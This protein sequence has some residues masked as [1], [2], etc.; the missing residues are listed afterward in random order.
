MTDNATRTD[1]ARAVRCNRP[2]PLQPSSAPASAVGSPPGCGGTAGRPNAQ[3]SMPDGWDRLVEAGNIHNLELAAG[4]TTGDYATTCRSWTATSTSGSRR[5]A[6]CSADRARTRQTAE[7]LQA[8]PRHERRRCSREA[9]QDDGYLDSYVQVDPPASGSAAS[10]LG[11]R[12]VLRRTSDPGRGRPAPEHRRR[13][14]C[15]TSPAGSPTWSTPTSA[16]ATARSTA[17]AATRRSRPRWSS[18]SGR[19][20]SERYLDTA[21]LLHRPARPRPAR[22]RTDFGGTTG[23][24]TCPIREAPS[25]EGHSVRQLYLLAGVADVVRRDRRR[26]LLE[27]AER[28]WEEMVATKTYLTGGVGAH[29]SDEAFGDPYELPNERSYCETCAAIASVMLSWRMLLITGEARYADLI[30]RTLYNG[31]LAGRLARTATSTS[32]PTRCRSATATLRRRRRRRTERK[33]WFRCACCPPNVMRTLASLEH[34]VVAADDTSVVLHQY[35]PGTLR[36]RSAPAGAARRAR[37]TYPW[38]GSV[39]IA[40]T[41]PGRGAWALGV[42]V[43]AWSPRRARRSTGRPSSDQPRGRLAADHPDWQPATS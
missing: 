42:R 13:P 2:T 27:A 17:S 3:V 43:P 38:D 10:P 28:L 5:S 1:F 23:R 6:G 35:I 24:T 16:R 30:E 19:P 32:T 8:A 7:R 39:A 33:P 22:R 4:T 18:C 9:Q 29:H 20:V 12:A 14:I 34:Y 40:S 11:P 26:P 15:S 37:P 21:Q 36:A 31:F 41:R 25:V